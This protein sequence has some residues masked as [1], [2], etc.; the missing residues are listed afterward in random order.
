MLEKRER[1]NLK[2]GIKTNDL[3]VSCLMSR[4]PNFRTSDLSSLL[5]SV[6]G[7]LT[8]SNKMARD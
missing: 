4:C 2:F 3:K 8:L 1:R 6:E 5:K 7:S